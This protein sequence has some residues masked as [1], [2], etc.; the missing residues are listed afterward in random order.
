LRTPGSADGPEAAKRVHDVIEG[1]KK[2]LNGV[3]YQRLNNA[4][5]GQYNNAK[6]ML[7]QAEEQL[8][9]SN[10]DIARNLAEKAT[11]IATELQGR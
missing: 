4:Q 9:G 5:R 6:L 1:A 10:F 11:R 8:K 3:N 7:T 2:A